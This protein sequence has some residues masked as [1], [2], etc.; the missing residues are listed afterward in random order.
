MSYFS[1]IPQ[2]SMNTWTAMDK[3][4]SMAPK[5]RTPA[6]FFRPLPSLFIR[7]EGINKPAYPQGIISKYLVPNPGCN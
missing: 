7:A 4:I 6:M 3:I 2:A 1:L 5:Q